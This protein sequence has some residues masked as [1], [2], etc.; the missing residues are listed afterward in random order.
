[1]K[2][3]FLTLGLFAALMLGGVKIANSCV[4]AILNM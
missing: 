2:K 1:M 4:T 3:K